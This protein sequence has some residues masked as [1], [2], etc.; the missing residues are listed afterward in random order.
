MLLFDMLSIKFS[1]MRLCAIQIF[2]AINLAKIIQPHISGK[3]YLR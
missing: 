3:A 2:N 1:P